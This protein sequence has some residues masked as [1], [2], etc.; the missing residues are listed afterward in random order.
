M[1]VLWASPETLQFAV[2]IVDD[3]PIPFPDGAYDLTVSGRSPLKLQLPNQ[4][5]TRG[6]KVTP[7]RFHIAAIRIVGTAPSSYSIPFD[8]MATVWHITPAAPRADYRPF[9]MEERVFDGTLAFPRAQDSAPPPAPLRFGAPVNDSA[10]RVTPTITYE[11]A[12]GYGINAKAVVS[13]A[14]GRA[15]TLFALNAAYPNACAPGSTFT[16]TGPGIWLWKQPD[17]TASVTG[18]CTC[19]VRFVVV[20]RD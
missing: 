7:I 20:A 19:K 18:Q 15:V 1:E 16:A 14:T 9:T 4:M 3:A 8:V 17:W 10:V 12:A 5:L 6:M 13:D 2:S 11:C